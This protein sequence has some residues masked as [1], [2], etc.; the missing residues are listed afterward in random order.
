MSVI[1]GLVLLPFFVWAWI[2]NDADED[3]AAA[4]SI[5]AWIVIG[6]SALAAAWYVF[7]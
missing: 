2:K 6:V 1:I 5:A 3:A 7:G 4:L